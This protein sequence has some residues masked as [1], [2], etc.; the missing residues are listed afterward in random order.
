[1]SS[2]FGKINFSD[3]G[4]IKEAL[5]SMKG[6]LNHWNA[7]D[8]NIWIKGKIG[9]GHLMLYNTPES[10]FEKL[11]L[12]D[13]TN[14]LTI[15][16]DARIDNREELFT[17]LS[18]TPLNEDK[19]SDSTL[20]LEMYKQY[21]ED[22]IHHLIGD[23]SFCIW[24]GK[25]KQ[26]FCARDQMGVK[27]FFYYQD[28]NSFIFATEKKG[29]LIFPGVDKAI[30]WPYFYNHMFKPKVQAYDTTFYLN[31]KRLP[32]AHVLILDIKTK[33]TNLYEYW[34]L[35]AYKELKLPTKEAYYEGLLQHLEEAVRCR[36][37]SNYPIGAELSGGLDSS[38]ITGIANTFLK[39]TDKNLTTISNTFPEGLEINDQLKRDEREYIE[40][41][42]K[43]NDI[44]DIVYV[45]ENLIKDPIEEIDFSLQLNDGPDFHNSLWQLPS[46]KAAQ[47]KG[48]RTILSGFPGD[49]MV[50]SRPSATLDLL[51]KKKYLAY[52]FSKK[53]GLSFFHKFYPLFPP[54]LIYYFV[55]LKEKMGIC[56]KKKKAIFALY[57]IPAKFK[58][59]D[60]DTLWQQRT[61]RE[62]YKSFR[63]SQKQ[64]I[65][66]PRINLRLETETT[67]ALHFKIEPRFPMADIRLLQYYS[68]LP[69]ELKYGGEINRKMFREA[70]HKYLPDKIAKRQDKF[71][72]IAPFFSLNKDKHADAVKWLVQ[73]LPNERFIKKKAVLKK[74]DTRYKNNNTSSITLEALLNKYL[75][76]LDILR[77]I[78]QN[79][80]H[81]KT[82]K[83]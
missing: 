1:M 33:E 46:R 27:P 55:S 41:V 42:N 24:D 13:S 54:K 80:Q 52:F 53:Q 66:Q 78:Q 37:R 19:I 17:K 82:G 56:N 38:T 29:I 63:H 39:N 68:S 77:W 76:A 20:I 18:I 60:I 51:D 15:T 28:K 45:S 11:P 50:T 61:Y 73:Q 5:S 2:I 43:F 32:P 67:T 62:R 74:I 26:L 36:L 16:A 3:T 22:V 44:K 69:N 81:L 14:D 64:T 7:D 72:A 4:S 10:L 9:L 35:D 71:G 49:Q 47:E 8:S 65:S 25:K 75:P 12:H 30:N 40:E 34:E 48:I 23:F 31:I 57:K 6:V 83:K 58:Q 59:A 70:V 21:G 79:E